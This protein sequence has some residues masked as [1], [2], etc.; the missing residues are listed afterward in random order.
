MFY[1]EYRNS[2]Q[3]VRYEIIQA[4]RCASPNNSIVFR[5]SSRSL[6]I[7]LHTA[8]AR[9]FSICSCLSSLYPAWKFFKQ[10][11][12]IQK[13]IDFKKLNSYLSLTSMQMTVSLVSV[14]NVLKQSIPK[15]REDIKHFKANTVAYEVNYSLFLLLDIVGGRIFKRMYFCWLSFWVFPTVITLSFFSFPTNVNWDKLRLI[16]AKTTPHHSQ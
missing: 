2:F 8:H 1:K 12:V 6:A 4:T 11:S 15:F 13:L 5:Q 3:A 14:A 7:Q 9:A 10:I 16:R